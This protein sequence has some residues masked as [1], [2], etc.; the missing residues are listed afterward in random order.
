[1]AS[2]RNSDGRVWLEL[3]EFQQLPNKYRNRLHYKPAGL[4]DSYIIGEC[5]ELTKLYI[6]IADAMQFVKSIPACFPAIEF[7]KKNEYY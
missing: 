4:G 3:G 5:G 1:M 6:P 2:F 7:Q